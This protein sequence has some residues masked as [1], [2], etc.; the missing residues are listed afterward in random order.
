MM[1]HTTLALEQQITKKKTFYEQASM[2]TF[3]GSAGGDFCIQN[4][5][6]S[7]KIFTL[8]CSFLIKRV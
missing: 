2:I 7:I 1:H 5:D 4:F 3:L 8:Y 6:S